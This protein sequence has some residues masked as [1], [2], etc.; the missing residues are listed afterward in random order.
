M[1]PKTLRRPLKVFL[2]GG[3]AMTFRNLKPS[4]KDVDLLFEDELGEKAF[5]CALKQVF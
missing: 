1:F 5:F 3:C 2:I 4:T